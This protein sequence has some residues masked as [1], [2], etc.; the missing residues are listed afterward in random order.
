MVGRNVGVCA[1]EGGL[2]WARGGVGQSQHTKKPAA[3]MPT[4]RTKTPLP[5]MSNSGPLTNLTPLTEGALPRT[6]GMCV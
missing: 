1:R 6:L 3:A 4:S 2:S 5:V